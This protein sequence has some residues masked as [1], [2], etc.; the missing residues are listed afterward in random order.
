MERHIKILKDYVTTLSSDFDDQDNFYVPLTL[1]VTKP[2]LIRKYIYKTFCQTD[3]D[4][5]DL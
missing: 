1:R 4:D 5:F 3:V 2:T